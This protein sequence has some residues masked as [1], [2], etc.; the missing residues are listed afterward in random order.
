MCEQ[1]VCLQSLGDPLIDTYPI[2]EYPTMIIAAITV[3]ALLLTTQMAVKIPTSTYI[4]Q[5]LLI[6]PFVL[7]RT[8]SFFL[9]RSETCTGL[10]S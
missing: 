2:G 1:D 6:D 10:K 4:R 5:D 7:T 9:S 3:P 8:P